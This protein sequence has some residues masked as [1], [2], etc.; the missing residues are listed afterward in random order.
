M[1]VDCG[2]KRIYGD[3]NAGSLAGIEKMIAHYQP[4]FIVLQDVKAKDA[5]RIKRIKRLHQKAVSAIS[6]AS[7]VPAG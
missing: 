6:I 7:Q 1:I 2:K 3:K 5:R 4:C